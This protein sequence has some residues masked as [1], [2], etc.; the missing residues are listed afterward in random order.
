[1]GPRGCGCSDL[2]QLVTLTL[3]LDS[4]W[5]W[6]EAPPAPAIPPYEAFDSATA[7]FAHSEAVQLCYSHGPS[8]STYSPV[9]T[10]DPAP[11]LE[12]PGPGLQVYPSED[13]ASQVRSKDS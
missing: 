10:L 4:T 1:M 2:L 7:A 9:G 13:F 6:T 3:L 8:P 12:A 5:G 11:S